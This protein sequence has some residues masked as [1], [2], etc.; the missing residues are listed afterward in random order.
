M[1]PQLHLPSFSYPV[2]YLGPGDLNSFGASN[3][4]LPS[5]YKLLFPLPSSHFYPLFSNSKIM[6]LDN[7]K[8]KS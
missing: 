4:V 1:T 8:N 2:L 6:L 3:A 5:P 7:E